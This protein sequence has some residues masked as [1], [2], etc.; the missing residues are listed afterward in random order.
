MSGI[1]VRYQA[2]RMSVD[3][4]IKYICH[5]HGLQVVGDLPSNVT[6]KYKRIEVRNSKITPASNNRDKIQRFKKVQQKFIEGDFMDWS[7]FQ[8]K[9]L[10]G[11]FYVQI[12]F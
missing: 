7:E 1:K 10:R 4:P 3:G 12:C 8:K 5:D 11:I 2:S 9:I 6:S